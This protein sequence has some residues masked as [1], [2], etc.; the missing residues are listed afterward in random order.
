MK[1]LLNWFR[2]RNLESGL[3]RELSYHFERRINDLM[4]AGL[5]EME[6]R[7]QVKLEV[8]SLPQIREEVRDVWLTRWMRDFA[9]DLRFSLRSFLRNPSFTATAVVSLALGIG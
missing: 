4:R 5:T 1:Q 2:R 6:A 7:R 8:G 9:Y 3:D